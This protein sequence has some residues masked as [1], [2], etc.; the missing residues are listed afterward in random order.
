MVHTMQRIFGD[1][2]IQNKIK[3]LDRITLQDAMDKI[4]IKVEYC[5]NPMHPQQ[6]Q[7]QQQDSDPADDDSSSDSSDDE[8]A[9]K[10]RKEKKKQKPAIIPELQDLGVYITS[11]KPVKDDFLAQS[12]ADRAP[13]MVTNISESA[14]SKLMKTRLPE[15]VDHTSQYAMR[16]Y[17]KGLRVMSCVSC[18]IGQILS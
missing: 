12:A 2:L 5:R 14:L 15:I 16:V 11:I 13:K 8:D 1:R 10:I 17:P 9:R 6:Q 4:L 3:D 7:Q 18:L